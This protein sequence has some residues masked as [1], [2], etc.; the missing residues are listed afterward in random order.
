M[1]QEQTR[2]KLLTLYDSEDELAKV[3]S[4]L[5]V[6]TRR[7]IIKIIA[8]AP[9][10]VN[11]IAWK[12]NIPVSTASFHI[13]TLVDANI[14]RYTSGSNKRGNEK[15]VSLNMVMFN[16][17]LDRNL[18]IVSD[19]IQ[20]INVPIGSYTSYRAEPTCGI[21]TPDGVLVIEDTP[22]MFSSPQRFNAGHIWLKCGYLEYKVPL[23][24]YS[25]SR[26][27]GTNSVYDKRAIRSVSFRFELC[28]ETAMYDHNCKSDITFSVNG[29]EACTFLSAGD[30]GEHRGRLN[31][32]WHS[33]RD[34][35][36]GLLYN[37]DIRYDGTYLNEK[38]VSELAVEDLNL[39]DNDLLTFRIEVKPDAKHVGGFNLFGKSFGDYP[40]DIDIVVTYQNVHRTAKNESVTDK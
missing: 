39:L 4:A 6:Q 34:S 29:M 15:L 26:S 38:R 27:V 32:E 1:D 14:L 2:L 21:N 13:K 12:L 10:S 11:E 9:G 8:E 24:N 16:L 28:S 18:A 37:I 36:Y 5:S 35:Q 22:A 19:N 17:M 33:S 25:G 20:V 30:F 3:C 7:D 40:Q 31:P 23:L